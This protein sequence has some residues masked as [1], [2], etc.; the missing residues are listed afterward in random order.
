MFMCTCRGSCSIRYT[1][2]KRLA[3]TYRMLQDPRFTHMGISTIAYECGFGDITA[4]NRAFRRHYG[5]SPSDVRHL[6]AS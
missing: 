4:F 1:R 3:R 6:K 2:A 5:A